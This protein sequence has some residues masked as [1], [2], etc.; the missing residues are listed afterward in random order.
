MRKMMLA[1]GAF[2]LVLPTSMVVS[3]VG[4]M[5]KAEAKRHLK[6]SK[7]RGRYVCH[8]SGGT[9][10]AIVGGIGGALLGRTIDTGGDR[11]AGTLIGGGAG[12]LAGREIDRGSKR[13]NC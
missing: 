9:T 3:A 10:G 13:R 2:S 11:T 12:A 1:L 5:G 4:P 6:Y 8:K 7:K